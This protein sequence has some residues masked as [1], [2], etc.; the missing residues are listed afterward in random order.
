MQLCFG[1]KFEGGIKQE[2]TQVLVVRKNILHI[3]IS[4]LLIP[5]PE[6]QSVLLRGKRTK[7]TQGGLTA[8]YVTVRPPLGSPSPL[9]L[10]RFT[11]WLPLRLQSDTRMHTCVTV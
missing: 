8:G 3:G 9:Q 4:K 1:L 10:E 2:I 5:I 6:K 7:G 11:A